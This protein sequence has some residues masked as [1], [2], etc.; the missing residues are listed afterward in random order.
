MITVVRPT[1][2]RIAELKARILNPVAAVFD[3]DGTCT[4]PQLLI[5]YMLYVVGDLSPE[6]GAIV[7]PIRDAL[8]EYERRRTYDYEPV[9]RTAV[10]AI[11]SFFRGLSF[12]DAAFNART[13]IER[14]GS[15]TY[16]FPRLLIGALRSMPIE[17]R[18]L[19]I[20]ITAQPDFLAEPFGELHGFDLVY[21]TPY[22]VVDGRFTGERDDRTIFHKGEVLDEII[23]TFKLHAQRCLAVGDSSGDIPM[24]ERVGWAYGVNPKGKLFDWIRRNPSYWVNDAQAN[25]VTIFTSGPNRKFVETCLDDALPDYVPRFDLPNCNS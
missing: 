6:H 9:M 19:I 8:E 1:P 4:K 14:F 18:G 16:M 2:E 13:V 10:A 11:P 22:E 12:A 24:L 21:S 20:A 25:G 5:E 23:A 15:M 17:E 3:I 7:K